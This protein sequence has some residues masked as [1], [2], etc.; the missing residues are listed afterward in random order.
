MFFPDLLRT[1]TQRDEHKKVCSDFSAFLKECLACLV[2]ACQIAEQSAAKSPEVYHSTVILLT[3]H[4]IEY[5]DGVAILISQGGSQPCLPLLRRALEAT[6]G[7]MYILKA[8]TKRRA[9]A[10]QVA[11]THRKLKLYDQLDPTTDEGKRLRAYLGAD[12][13][14]IFNKVP[15]EFWPKLLKQ[16]QSLTGMLANADYAPIEQ[17]WQ[18]TK[19][20]EPNWYS[21]FGGP[22][23]ARE[24][25]KR[26]ARARPLRKSGS[27]GPRRISRFRSRT[28]ASG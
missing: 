21:L 7:V 1:D 18:A 17:E 22:Q 24:L 14:E 9:L 4:V 20:K 2:E 13:D 11:H 19:K 5:V 23:N 6:M 15:I 25:V 16:I 10:Y 8:D 12:A 26:S 28:F 27:T 3:R